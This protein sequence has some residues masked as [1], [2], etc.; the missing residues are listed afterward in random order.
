MIW[1]QVE[2]SAKF[3]A[4]DEFSLDLTG[5]TGLINA[6]K[7]LASSRFVEVTC[8]QSFAATCKWFSF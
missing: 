1:S 2:D 4:L 8:K 5:P 6:C 7:N 3:Y